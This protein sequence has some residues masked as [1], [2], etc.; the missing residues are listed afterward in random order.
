[1]SQNDDADRVSRISEAFKKFETKQCRGSSSL[2]E[3]LS[4]S[5]S[6]DYE[7]LSLAA[8][9]RK[10]QPTPNLFLAAVH[11]LLLR[12]QNH[13]LV[14][15]Y[16]SLVEKPDEPGGVFPVF[17]S[18][19]LENRDHIAGIVSHRIVQT[20]EVQRSACLLP[21]ITAVT[22]E[23]GAP[24][25]ILEI[26]ASAGFNLLFDKFCYNYGEGKIYGNRASPVQ[27]Y[28][29]L[30]GSGVPR[31]I[32]RNL[33]TSRLGSESGEPGEFGRCS[34]APCPHLAGTP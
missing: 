19:C 4:D 34:M 14:A 8:E 28:C 21:G 7:M 25:S 16:A 15:F 27:L 32:P 9:C 20:N 17:R 22:R 2:Y 11:Y 5:I 18:F 6:S 26:G 24:I 30:R 12:N 13:P 1:M 29:S 10:G 3:K 23:F 33:E 31:Q